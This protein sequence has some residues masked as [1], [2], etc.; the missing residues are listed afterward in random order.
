M[1]HEPTGPVSEGDALRELMRANGLTQKALEVKVGI[2]QSTISAVLN[3]T[4]SLTK[5]QV[6]RLARHFGIRP[7]AFLPR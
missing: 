6:I 2:A 1:V 4:R 7:S 3:G 5:D